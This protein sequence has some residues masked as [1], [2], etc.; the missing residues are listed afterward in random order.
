[1]LNISGFPAFETVVGLAFLFFLLSTVCSSINE[2]IANVLGWR[3]K[4]LEDA[5]RNMFDDPGVKRHW[6]EWFGRLSD[7]AVRVARAHTAARRSAVGTSE[8][9]AEAKAAVDDALQEAHLTELVMS[10]H[11]IRSLVRNPDSPHRRR[12]RPSYLPPETLSRA[13]TETLLAGPT[14][15]APERSLWE[16]GNEALMK[17]LNEAID[18]LP[19]GGARDTLRRAALDA[20]QSVERFRR[21]I[22]DGFDDVMQRASGWYKRKV[23]LMIAVVAA[24]IAIGLNVD[25]LQV[26][27][28]LWSNGPVRSAVARTAAK[29][30]DAPQ[31]AAAAKKVQ[32]LRLPLG[33]G[34][35]NA[36]EG[37]D[38]WVRRIPGWLI[39]IAAITL[40]AP[41]WFDAL[42]RL[43]RLRGSG[44]PERPRSLSDAAGT[45]KR[46]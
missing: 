32:E 8:E 18:G 5:L 28:A 13:L 39:T 46:T 7:R 45:Q 30:A 19:A 16:A 6:K 12:A 4:T 21:N 37:F 24:V 34:A 15:S 38:G 22:E 40:G 43:A 31:A 42:S 35:G 36:P 23:Q 9:R 17:R 1:V 44:V 26:A 41:F 11:H 3:A 25:S 14:A 20:D 2:S 29:E 33:W 27:D 10:N